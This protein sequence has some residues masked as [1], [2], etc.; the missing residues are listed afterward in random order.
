LFDACADSAQLAA[1]ITQAAQAAIN[2]GRIPFLFF[3][4]QV[5]VQS[6]AVASDT[7]IG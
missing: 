7:C 1:N 3:I 6:I 2:P 4:I 5:S